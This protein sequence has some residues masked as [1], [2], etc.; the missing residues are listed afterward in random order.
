MWRAGFDA[1]VDVESSQEPGAPL[2]LQT[3]HIVLGLYETITDVAARSRFC[4]ALVTLSLHG[5]QIGVLKIEA[6]RPAGA[7][8]TSGAGSVPGDNDDAP[9]PASNAV[10]YPTGE[11]IDR[12]D[13]DFSIS[14]TYTGASINSK[15]II[16]AVLDALTTAAQSAPGA[17]FRSLDAAS[18]SGICA[19]G[20]RGVENPLGI[21]YSYVTK[22]LRTIVSDIMVPLRRFG[23]MTLRILWQGVKIGEGEVRLAGQAL[24]A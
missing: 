4:A 23:E 17:F 7:S 24:S 20:V 6:R 3:N 5:R 11:I 2:R 18:A 13:P 16:L 8:E 21:N 1:E 12:D 15:E 22:A 10:T 14:Y 19:I 9:P